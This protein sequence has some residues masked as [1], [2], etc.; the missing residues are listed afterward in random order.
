[1]SNFFTIGLGHYLG[2]SSVLFIIGLVGICLNR[3]NII[4]LLMGIEIVLLA[5]NINFVAFS[6]FLADLMGQIFTF[7]ILT[8]AASEIAIGLAILVVFFRNQ[9]NISVQSMERLRG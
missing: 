8:V 6:V 5:V 3:R 4:L 9:G 2:V 7:F 1:M